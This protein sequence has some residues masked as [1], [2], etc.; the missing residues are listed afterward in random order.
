VNKGSNGSFFLENNSDNEI[1]ARKSLISYMAEKMTKRFTACF[2]LVL[3]FP[4]F[5]V[6]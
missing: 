2:L 5:K 4:T 1:K 6:A 3:V